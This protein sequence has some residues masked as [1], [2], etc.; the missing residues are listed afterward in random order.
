MCG[1]ALADFWPKLERAQSLADK[2]LRK[3]REAR[4]TPSSAQSRLTSADSWVTRA[5][6]EADKYK[7]DP[8]GSK[9]DADKPDEA[10]VRAATRDVQHAKSA[11]SKAQSDVSRRGRGLA[12]TTQTS[13]A[14]R[15]DTFSIRVLS[16]LLP[17][18]EQFDKGA[19]GCITVGDFEE[20]FPMD[21][22]YWSVEQ[23]RESWIQSLRVLES[24]NEATSCLISSITDPANTNFIFCCPLY[25]SGNI[26]CVQNSAIFL[27]EIEEDFAP[28]EPWRFVE[29][30]SAFDEDGN[31]VS[32]WQTSFDA[33]SDFLRVVQS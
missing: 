29:P 18:G 25:R 6:K 16:E 5:G 28:G 33:V 7:D 11:Q 9:S 15:N 22:T 20:N 21:L 24:R 30:R 8:T 31:E 10:K 1:D 13:T 14:S 27:E 4:D 32:E 23:Y 26:V 12:P 19:V 17:A 2:A 3:G